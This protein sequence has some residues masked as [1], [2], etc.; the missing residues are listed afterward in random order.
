[1]DLSIILMIVVGILFLGYMIV[2]GIF[3]VFLS[4]KYDFENKTFLD[5]IEENLNGKLI[6]SFRKSPTCELNEEPLIL[7]KFKAVVSCKCKEDTF[8]RKCTEQEINDECKESFLIE[9]KDYIKINSEYICVTKSDK[10]YLSLLQGDNIKSKNEECLQDYKL[11]GIVDTLDNKL[12]V[13]NEDNC[14]LT[15]NEI[16]NFTLLSDNDNDILSIFRLDQ[17]RDFPCMHPNEKKWNFYGD[18]QVYFDYCTSKIKG[19]LYDFRYKKINIVTNQYDLYKDN[20]IL[21]GMEKYHIDI[22]DLKDEKV[23]F[24]GRTFLGFD[25]KKASNYNRETLKDKQDLLN[26]CLSAIKIVT[27]IVIAPLIC[28]GG[29]GGAASGGGENVGI[30]CLVILLIISI[31]SSIIYFILSIIILVN[32]N[33]I[34]SLLDLGSDQYTNV[35][36]KELMDGT[37]INFGFSLCT[38]IVFPIIL[39]SAPI[40]LCHYYS[41]Y[42]Y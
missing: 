25:P 22:N 7:D 6:Y 39:I 28:I 37:S 31:P 24:F 5:V 34:E 23:F 29:I 30:C 3:G 17:N 19:E 11:C 26:N 33:A 41:R 4:S 38:I 20:D 32:H 36:I 40:I 8:T 18:I 2:N 9:S 10:N 12:C 1:M 13:K 15:I 35:L 27:Y 14:P 16:N 21:D 42:R